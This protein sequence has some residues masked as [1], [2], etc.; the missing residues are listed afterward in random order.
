MINKGDRVRL[1]GKGYTGF[2]IA[3]EMDNGTISVKQDNGGIAIW[4]AADTEVIEA[5]SSD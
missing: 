4:V 5:A 3:D 2:A 1:K